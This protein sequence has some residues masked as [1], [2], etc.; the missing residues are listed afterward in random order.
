[1]GKKMTRIVMMILDA[2]PK[3]NQR[4]SSGARAKNGTAWLMTRMGMTQRCTGRQAAMARAAATPK[5]VPK[6]RPSR[7]SA[8][9]TT[10]FSNR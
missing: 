10:R 3:P 8:R 1:M 2:M 6:S 4:T 5:T 7:I 9:V